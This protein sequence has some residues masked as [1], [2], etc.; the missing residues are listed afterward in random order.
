MVNGTRENIIN[1]FFKLASQ[2]P[3]RAH[4]TI[5]EIANEAH[6]SRQAIYKNHFNST[7]E[8]LTYL[9]ETIDS[10][11]MEAF[12]KYDTTSDLA[13]LEY[14]ANTIIPIIYER[15]IWLKLLYSTS[16]D[17]QWRFYLKQK[18]IGWLLKN[19]TINSYKEL[20]LTKELVVQHI[21]NNILSIIEIWLATDIPDHPQKFSK[22]FLKLIDCSIS[23]FIS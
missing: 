6:L 17:P 13:P 3:E 1:A 23:D 22:I 15:R 14:F 16:V 20:G 18:Y 10:E 19:I 11:V 12:D 4:F 9:H 5:A 7:K 8:I 2:H 21:V